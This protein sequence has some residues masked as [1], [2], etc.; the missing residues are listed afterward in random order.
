MK[1][2]IHNETY[3]VGFVPGREGRDNSLKTIFLMQEAIRSDI[4]AA[5][6]LINAEKA[7]DRVNWGFMAETL[8]H[9]GIGERMMRWILSLYRHPKA[10][11]RVNGTLSSPL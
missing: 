7:L 6:L 1:Q 4:P 2:W 8:K 3:Q 9:L 5:L 10:R 11:I